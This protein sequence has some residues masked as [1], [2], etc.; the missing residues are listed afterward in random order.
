MRPILAG[1]FVLA[2]TACGSDG[3][4]DTPPS[5]ASATPTKAAEPVTLTC[6]AEG[7]S[8]FNEASVI[9]TPTTNDV[10]TSWG[11]KGTPPAS[12][13]F[14]LFVTL[15][16][17]GGKEIH[18]LGFKTQDGAQVGFFDFDMSTANQRNITTVV[19]PL[20]GTGVA[21]SFTGS[22]APFASGFT[23][24]GAVSVDGNDVMTCS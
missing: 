12:G 15:T 18:Q 9:V 4:A 13:T 2:L 8:P 17:S 21:M 16:G 11:W 24:K 6:T 7:A 1:L 20:K 19:P 14:G 5:V 10:R 3:D 22:G 23:A